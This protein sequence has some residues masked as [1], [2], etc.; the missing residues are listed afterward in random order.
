M[1]D[2]DH[3]AERAA[4]QL[5][6]VQ[7]LILFNQFKILEK[8]DPENAEE[9]SQN[10]EILDEGYVREYSRLRLHQE[11]G[12]LECQEVW[13]T[14]KMY[15]YL[16]RSYESVED[17]TGLGKLAISFPGFSS[18]HETDQWAYARFIKQHGS[19]ERVGRDDLDSGAPM[20]KQYKEMLTR[21]KASTD[22]L[23]LTKEDIS[24][25][26]ALGGAVEWPQ[27]ARLNPDS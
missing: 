12:A 5:T 4:M 24:R 18:N 19:W 14:L 26:V 10:R 20:L 17:K 21:W 9:Y 1:A 3:A 25:I 13:D 6:E 11:L 23:S 8:L 22:P 16:Q 27:S 15:A 2:E 7:R